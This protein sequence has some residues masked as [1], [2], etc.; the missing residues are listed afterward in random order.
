MPKLAITATAYINSILL[1]NMVLSKCEFSQSPAILCSYFLKGKSCLWLIPSLK[2]KSEVMWRGVNFFLCIP[3]WVTHVNPVPSVWYPRWR[4]AP[5]KAACRSLSLQHSTSLSNCA[6]WACWHCAEQVRILSEI[7]G[8]D[9][10]HM[11]SSLFV[12]HGGVI[13]SGLRVS[14][15]YRAAAVMAPDQNQQGTKNVLNGWQRWWQE[16]Q[17]II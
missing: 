9:L 8:S 17:G 1:L 5:L 3:P 4:R 6:N 12:E 16:R 11:A 15:S 2:R 13:K 14:A 7:P 10:H